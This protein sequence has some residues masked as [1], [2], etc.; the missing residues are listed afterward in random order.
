MGNVYRPKLKTG[1]ESAIWW[2]SF[3]TDGKRIRESSRTTNKRKAED[4]LKEREGR[5]VTG[6]PILPRADKIRY[7]EARADL[8]AHYGTFETRDITEAIGRLVHLDRF[9]DGRRI[10]GIGPADVT[11][12]AS[13][14]RAAGAANG[15]INRELATLSKMLH[16]AARNNKL[17]RLQPIQ[18][19]EADPRAG[20]V[21][22]A[23]FDAI[24][25]HLPAD[26]K[27]G[28]LIAYTFGWRKQEVF[29]RQ[30]RQLD[31]D[32]GT[33]RLD[34]GET[35]NGEGRI[36]HVTPELRSV[37]SAQVARVRALERKLGRLI[38]HLFPH[39]SGR[40][41]GRR[42]GDPRKAWARACK[43]AGRPGVLF[44]DLRRSAVRNMERPG[45]ARSVAMKMTGHKT[46]SVYRRYAIVS[47]AELQAAAQK[48]AAQG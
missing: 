13:A 8:L 47:D 17:L 40:H 41:V 20:F 33:L 45:I 10:C 38:P 23:E 21:D 3:Y 25:T 30:L 7:A 9:F 15:T 26:L 22:R 11:D 12:Y 42:F 37:L 14:R 19:P 6:Q 35:K 36:V 29:S 34:P 5:V 48:L 4:L 2:L 1:A 16:V 18:L 32:A 39:L 31:L 27:A 44:H 43:K 28:A 24:S 46:E